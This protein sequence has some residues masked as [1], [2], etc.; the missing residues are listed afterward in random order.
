MCIRLPPLRQARRAIDPA[1]DLRDRLRDAVD[2]LNRDEIDHNDKTQVGDDGKYKKVDGQIHLDEM[3][4]CTTCGGCH[5]TT[6]IATHSYHAAVGYDETFEG[7]ADV[8]APQLV[9][10]GRVELAVVAADQ[11]LTLRAAGGRVKAIFACFQS[12]SA[13]R[14]KNSSSFGFDSG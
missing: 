11:L 10:S 9:A 14:A 12:M 7:G 2:L 8:P 13:A 3:W 6:Y 5:N 4:G 1:W